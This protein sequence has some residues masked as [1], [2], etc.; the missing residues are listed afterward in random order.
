MKLVTAQNVVVYAG[1]AADRAMIQEYELHFKGVRGSAKFNV[2]LTTYEM[3]LKDRSLL[4]KF[5]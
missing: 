4:A 3:V 5:R 1:S 2:L